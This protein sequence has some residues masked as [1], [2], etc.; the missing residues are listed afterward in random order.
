MDWNSWHDTYD[1]AGS[2]LGRRLSAVQEQVRTALDTCPPGPVRVISVCA[3]QGR[4]LLGVLRDH[5]RRG[6]V[7]GRLVE[8]DAANVA[9]ARAAA[10]AA[11]L[12]RIEVVQG[13][14]A[15]TDAYV[16][17]A[18][19]DLV[20]VCGVFGNISDEDVERT[21]GYCAQLCRDG[22]TLLWTRHRKAPDLVPQICDWLEARGFERRWLSAPDAGFGAGAHRFTRSPEP[23]SPGECMFTFVGYDVLAAT[24]GRR[25]DPAR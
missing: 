18:P 3:G 19:A 7:T 11:G 17:L 15:V 12:H 9:V 14:A 23:L 8:L 20:L 10:E 22:G 1:L 16:G 21:I 5:P 6:D 13:D 4:D 2:S 25:P 24:G